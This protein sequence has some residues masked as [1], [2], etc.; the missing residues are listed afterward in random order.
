MITFNAT[1]LTE[2]NGW[3]RNLGGPFSERARNSALSSC[4]YFLKLKAKEAVKNNTLGWKPTSYVTQVAKANRPNNLDPHP[5]IKRVTY[6]PTK[7]WGQIGSLVV[8]EVDKNAGFL[9]FGFKAG[10]YGNKTIRTRGGERKTVNE[11]FEG[12]VEIAKT[13]T[14]GARFR[15]TPKMSVYLRAIGFRINTWDWI[16][17]PARALVGPLFLRFQQ[18]LFQLFADKYYANVERYSGATAKAAA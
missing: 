9:D 18:E 1:N 7:A 6:R 16:N 10:R 12:I 17:I 8:Y 2:F 14:E 4:G 15:V 3:L 5:P 13:L 11:L